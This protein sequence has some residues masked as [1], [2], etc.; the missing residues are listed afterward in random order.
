[1]NHRL[2]IVTGAPGSGKSTALNAFLRIQ[3]PYLAF[4]IDWL[5]V[6]ASQ[7]AGRDIIFDRTTWPSY[8]AVWFDVLHAIHKNSKI[9]VFFAPLD[10]R[11]V[12]AYGQ[13]AWCD[14]IEWLLLDCA[15]TIRYDRLQRRAGWTT[16]M[17][18]E[19]IL[20]AQVLRQQIVE[21]IDTNTYTPDE[22]ATTILTWLARPY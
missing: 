10:Q 21:R 8:N 14:R 20:D 17:I 7:L 16:D 4:D 22:V 13:P 18:A 12:A 6:S 15:D 1:V 9:A 2:H 5:T 19:S 11:D 3:S